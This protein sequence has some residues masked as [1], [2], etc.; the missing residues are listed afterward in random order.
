MK[1]MWREKHYGIRH[2]SAYI[3]ISENTARDLVRFFP[4]I[5]EDPVT[6][7]YCGVRK[8]F[9]TSQSRRDEEFSNEVRDFKTILYVVL[10]VG[11][12][13]K[14]QFYSSA[15]LLNLPVNKALK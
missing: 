15:H 1:P 5:A 11:L 6:V 10:V 8:P 2:A 14:I 9:L 4:A 13:I 7:A 12:V 3:A